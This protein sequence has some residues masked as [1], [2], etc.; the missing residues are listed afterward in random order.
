MS[1]PHPSPVFIVGSPRSGTSLLVVALRNAAYFGFNEGNF[2]ALLEQIYLV[3]DRHYAAF[4]A[5]TPYCLMA[6]LDKQALKASIA[7]LFKQIVER[8][9]SAAPW[10]DKSGNAAM[11]RQI[12]LLVQ[13]WP[14][15]HFIFA[16]RRGIENVASRLKKFPEITFENHCKGWAN[17][18][19]AWRA[20]RAELP[21]LKCVE[22]EQQE[23]IRTPAAT[24]EHLGAF[25]NFSAV[26]KA[27]LVATFR[28]QRPEQTAAGTS[29][30]VL[31]LRTTGW[32]RR[33]TELFAQ[34]CAAEMDSFGYTLDETYRLQGFPP[35]RAA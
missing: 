33:Q 12:P 21:D 10:F 20:V 32:S 13:L 17:T 27:G 16:K 25:L 29:Q 8:A 28:E 5:D 1:T 34:H 4:G 23:L 18:M 22:I 3:T 24:S 19:S 30:R 9:N 2:F 11:I 31:S 7:E 35:S 15:A 6:H 14:E 26:Q